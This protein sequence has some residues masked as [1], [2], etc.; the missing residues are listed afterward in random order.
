MTLATLRP[1]FEVQTRVVFSTWIIALEFSNKY[2]LV[3]MN[4]ALRSSSQFGRILRKEILADRTFFTQKRPVS[5][6]LDVS[7]Q[8]YNGFD[9]L[10]PGLLN[11]FPSMPCFRKILHFESKLHTSVA[12]Q[13]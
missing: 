5:N 9:A 8:I 2:Y 4:R 10:S 7:C 13:R 6:N 1:L 11:D 12:V 3:R